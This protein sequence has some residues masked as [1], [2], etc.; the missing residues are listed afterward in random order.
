MLKT[1]NCHLHMKLITTVNLEVLVFCSHF[2][3]SGDLGSKNELQI[4]CFSHTHGNRL[5]GAIPKA[6]DLFLTM[7]SGVSSGSRKFKPYP[8]RPIPHPSSCDHAGP[9][10]L[11]GP[12]CWDQWTPKRH[13]AK[14]QQ[15]PVRDIHLRT[16][17]FFW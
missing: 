3:C 15:R 11:T 9:C 7:L 12:V 14:R 6:D 2:L 5:C 17:S 13:D 1:S 16:P 4:C 10:A 8:H